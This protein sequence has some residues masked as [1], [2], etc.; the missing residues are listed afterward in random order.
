MNVLIISSAQYSVTA[1]L[2]VQADKSGHLY[3]IQIRHASLARTAG[4]RLIIDIIHR[5]IPEMVP[6]SLGHQCALMRLDAA[7]V[8][9]LAAGSQRAAFAQPVRAL[10]AC[11]PLSDVNQARQIFAEFV[12]LGGRSLATTLLGASRCAIIDYKL[13]KYT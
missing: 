2:Y 1:C 4:P 3:Q 6:L 10:L 11:I 12:S 8:K 5:G 7:C 9:G 13:V